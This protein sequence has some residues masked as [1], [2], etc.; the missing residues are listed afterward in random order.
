MARTI[1]TVMGVSALGIV[2]LAYYLIKK[3]KSNKGGKAE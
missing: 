2:S 3:K 1:A